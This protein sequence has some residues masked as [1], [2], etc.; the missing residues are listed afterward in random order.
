M[1]ISRGFKGIWIPRDLWVSKDLSIQDKVFLAEIHSL[2]NNEGCIASNKYF[3]N[4]FGLSKGSVSR[5]ISKLK[6]KGYVTVQLIKNEITKEVEKRIIRVVKYG[7]EATP[8]IKEDIVEELSKA[9]ETQAGICSR[10]I[11]EFN[12]ITGRNFRNSSGTR[13][14]ILGRLNEG[15]GIEDLLNVTQVKTNQWAN[16]PKMCVYLRPETLFNA[17]K[18]PSYLEEYKLSLKKQSTSDDFLDTQ[19]NFYS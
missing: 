4:F 2:D 9:K 10:I 1:D 17:T 19:A 6:S 18:F 16:N 13:K 14:F 15:Y 11:S 8:M 7:E 3:A 5:I 12:A